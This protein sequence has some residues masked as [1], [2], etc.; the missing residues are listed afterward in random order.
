M[1]ASYDSA[2]GI[3]S[4]EIESQGPKVSSRYGWHCSNA[5][6]GQKISGKYSINPSVVGMIE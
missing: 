6:N 3:D 4:T 1:I 5:F 2:T